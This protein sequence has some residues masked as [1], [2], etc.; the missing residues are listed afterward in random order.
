[1]SV[2]GLGIGKLDHPKGIYYAQRT[3]WS[4]TYVWQVWRVTR[5]D[6]NGVGAESVVAVFL[7]KADAEAFARAKNRRKR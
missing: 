3:P 4:S 5:R 1:M 6:R 7:N 2:L